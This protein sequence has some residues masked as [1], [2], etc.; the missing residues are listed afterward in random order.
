MREGTKALRL[1]TG[2]ETYDL[3][4]C[5]NMLPGLSGVELI[6]EARR[7]VHRRG[8]PIIMLSA[9]E[10]RTAAARAGANAFLRKPEDITMIVEAVRRLLTAGGGD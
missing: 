8:L 10:V 1:L 9:E 6:R 5:D 4:L 3:L 2:K 7:L